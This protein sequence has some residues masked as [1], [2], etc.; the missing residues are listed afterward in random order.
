MG[1][2]HSRGEPCDV[3]PTAYADPRDGLQVPLDVPDGDAH[4]GSSRCH[5]TGS[6]HSRLARIP[7]PVPAAPSVPPA[8]S[9]MGHT[10]LRG[11]LGVPLT[12]SG[13]GTA[14]MSRT[15]ARRMPS[16][17]KCPLGQVSILCSTIRGALIGDGQG[18]A[19]PH[20]WC[21]VFSRRLAASSHA[22]CACPVLRDEP[23]PH[24]AAPSS[25]CSVALARLSL[26]A[27]P[28]AGAQRLPLLS[29]RPCLTAVTSEQFPLSR[30]AIHHS[31]HL[32]R[33]LTSLP[34]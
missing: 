4:S 22:S 30:Y 9:N 1:Y 11:P 16:N 28:P 31:L 8:L 34:E 25:G 12:G 19:P 13:G 18:R 21:A 2:A 10:S 7:A 29:G 17:W 5:Q 15:C 33:S 14:R 32:R 23:T 20:V 27:V 24:V 6:P 3:L 26:P